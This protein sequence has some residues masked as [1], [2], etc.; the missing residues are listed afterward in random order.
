MSP[1]MASEDGE[2]RI[3]LAVRMTCALLG[4]MELL[5]LDEVVLV[6]ILL[7]KSDEEER[8]AFGGVDVGEEEW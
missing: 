8:E 6:E 1:G 2:T 5:L 4:M 7:D 3:G